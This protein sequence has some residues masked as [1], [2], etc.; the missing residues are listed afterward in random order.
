MATLQAE[1]IADLIA[2][3]QKELGKNRITDLTSDLQYK[4]ALS[5]LMKKSRV[6][7]GSGTSINFNVLMNGDENSRNVGLFDVDNVNQVD[8]MKVGNVPWRHTT[9]A[10]AYDVKQ[11]AMNRTPAK[12]VDFVKEKRMQRLVGFSDLMEENFWG[13]PTDGDDDTSQFGLG[14]WIVYNATEGFNGGNNTNFASGPAGINRTTYPRWKNYTAQ[15]V[16]VT[17]VDLIRKWRKAATMCAFKPLVGKPIPGYGVGDRYGYYTNYDVLGPMEELL[18][19]QNDSLGNDVASKDGETLFRK[20]P[21]TFVPWL[22]D[23][24]GTCDP[25]VGI[26]WDVFKT[27]FL[28]GQYMRET[29]PKMSPASHDVYNAFL[30][31]T[32]NFICYDCR[33]LFLLAKSTWHNVA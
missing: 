15:Y 31:N 1:D 9:T 25:V 21:V 16:N 27:V 23:N 11:L 5:R 4:V 20:I 26:N 13:E 19:A 28:S 12:I 24:K 6:T 32:Y 10:Y 18:E 3:T 7:F 14:Y 8:G 17:K 30:D 29:K 33:K 2:T 22:Q